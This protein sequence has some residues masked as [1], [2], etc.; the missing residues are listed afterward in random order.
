MPVRILLLFISI[1]IYS[2]TQNQKPSSSEEKTG[3]E[4]GQAESLPVVSTD[5][6]AVHPAEM[7]PLEIVPWKKSLSRMQIL[8]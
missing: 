3:I 6:I 8:P 4:F 1:L 5:S 7:P 2:R